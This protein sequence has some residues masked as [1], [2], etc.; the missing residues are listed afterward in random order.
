MDWTAALLVPATRG[1]DPGVAR[2]GRHARS[3]RGGA[4]RGRHRPRPGVRH[5]VG[6]VLQ[7]DS[8]ARRSWWGWIC[9][10]GPSCWRAGSRSHARAAMTLNRCAAVAGAGPL[11]TAAAATL[12]IA[13]AATAAASFVSASAVY[14]HGEWD[15]WAQWNLRARF[16]ARGL[17]DGAW[18]DAFAP[19]LAW[20]HPDYPPLVPSS[21]ARLW[22]YAGRET[23]AGADRVRG[24]DRPPA[25]CSPPA[26]RPP[27]PAGRPADAWPP[28]PSSPVRRSCATPRRSAPTSRSRSSCWRPSSPGLCRPAPDTAGRCRLAAGLAGRRGTLRG[29]RRVD[30]ERRRRLFRRLHRGRRDR[31]DPGRRLARARGPG[32]AARRGGPRPRHRVRVQGDAGAG[33]LFRRGPIDGRGP[34]G[35]VQRARGRSSSAGRWRGSSG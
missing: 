21:I 34:G 8:V 15:A 32:T 25:S 19:V 3:T 27:A 30:Q 31:A 28:R 7:R 14:P 13:T 35:A 22:I 2:D 4:G 5:L 9:W 16:F 33:E 29:A 10:R 26:S 23:V 11:V 24:G 18:R 1:A 6:A 12:L 17:A 20:S